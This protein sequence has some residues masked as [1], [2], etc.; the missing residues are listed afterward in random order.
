MKKK[1]AVITFNQA[2]NYGAVLQMYALQQVLLFLGCDCTIIDYN[3]MQLYNTYKP[4]AILDFFVPRRCVS[5][6]FRNSY[7]KYNYSGFKTFINQ[8]IVMSE[9]QYSTIEELECLNEAYDF[10][11]AGSDQ[12]FN[13]Y[14]SG[15]DTNYLLQFV[16]DDKKKNSYAASLGLNKIPLEQEDLYKEL[17]SNYNY[18]SVREK[19]GAKLLKTLL[20]RECEVNVDPTLLLSPEKWYSIEKKPYLIS[21][22]TPYILVYV[23]SEDKKI[24]KFAKKLKKK[25]GYSIYY[26]NDRLFGKNG[27]VNL[28]QID[29]EEW[30]W[31]IH[32]AQHIVTNSFHGIAFSIN[33]EKSFFPFLLNKNTKVNS[34][35][36][37]ILKL[38]HLQNI[39]IENDNDIGE[40]IIDYKR[41]KEIQKK[42]YQKS[43]EYFEKIM[44]SY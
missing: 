29:P 6:L 35:I 33:F 38:F 10:F 11:I 21:E 17:L 37:D 28:R 27:L 20:N 5:V 42:E 22:R 9:N 15:F 2:I 44:E 7:I 16:K 1:C 8:Y 36:I 14:C 26:I 3:S 39:L 13:L 41:V 43:I 12:V 30:I 40:R 32:H 24:F 25:Y 4:M 19:T 18:I 34:R 23:L 31:L